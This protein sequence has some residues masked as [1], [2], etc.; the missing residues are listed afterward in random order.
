MDGD[1]NKKLTKSSWFLIGMGCLIL[2]CL[3]NSKKNNK[4]YHSD[5]YSSWEE[6]RIDELEADMA[7]LMD[8]LEK[9]N[10]LE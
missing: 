8:A 10:L 5:V 9:R 4:P 2:I 6:E 3:S 1:N 7:Y